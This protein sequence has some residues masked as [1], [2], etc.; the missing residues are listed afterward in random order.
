VVHSTSKA[1]T[2]EFPL[3]HRMSNQLN[4]SVGRLIKLGSASS[5]MAVGQ[6]AE[7]FLLPFLGK[8]I[9]GNPDIEAPCPRRV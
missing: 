6:A 2:I 9:S 8:I 1:A 5:V 4:G 7:R 3:S